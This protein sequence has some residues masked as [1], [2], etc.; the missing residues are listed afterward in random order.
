MS[1]GGNDRNI[2]KRSSQ[3]RLSL[4]VSRADVSHSPNSFGRDALVNERNRS[5]YFAPSSSL[6]RSFCETELISRYSLEKNTVQ[7]GTVT[8]L[9]YPSPAEG[10]RLEIVAE[11]GSKLIIGSRAVVLAIGA[12]SAPNVPEVIGGVAGMKEEE[13]EG[14]CHSSAFGREEF[15][16]P[17]RAVREAIKAKELTSML[18]IGGGYVELFQGMWTELMAIR[19]LT[20]AQIASL[21]IERGV[22]KVT[23]VCRGHLK[24]SLSPRLA[25]TIPDQLR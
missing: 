12:S 8:S 25:M 2:R 9:S 24:G 19:R 5:D 13:G 23:L 10:F 3:S 14:W 1:L 4:D 18:V 11:D 16:F 15:R 17:P 7:Q 20:S 22:S 6:F 21:A